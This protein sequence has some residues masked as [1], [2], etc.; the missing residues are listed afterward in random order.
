MGFRQTSRYVDHDCSR[1]DQSGSGSDYCL[2]GLCIEP[3]TFERTRLVLE[4]L[5]SLCGH[6]ICQRPVPAQ[7]CGLY[8][9][10]IHEFWH[11]KRSLYCYGI[12][13]RSVHCIWR[14]SFGILETPLQ[15]DLHPFLRIGSQTRL[16][17]IAIIFPSGNI[18]GRWSARR[19]QSYRSGIF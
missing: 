2:V 1:T 6:R 18:F 10:A 7:Q 15:V 12:L 4:I 3:F 14:S 11:S 8:R 16:A 9:L 17:R 5:S 13:R 19:A